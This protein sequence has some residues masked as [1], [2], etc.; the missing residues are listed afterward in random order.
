MIVSKDDFPV[1]EL[2]IPS[3]S[4]KKDHVMLYDFILH[5]S[6]DSVEQFQWTTQ[7]MYLKTIDRFHDLQVTCLLTPSNSKFLLLH[8]GKSEDAI[9]AFFNEVYDLFVKV[10]MNPFYETNSKITINSFEERVRH[11]SK[12]HF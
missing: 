6:L 11:S 10:V 9:K 4:K 7:N 12:K 1:F 3:L 2:P 5:S 8:D